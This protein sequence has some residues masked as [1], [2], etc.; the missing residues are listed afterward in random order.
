MGTNELHPKVRRAEQ[1]RKKLLRSHKS[2]KKILHHT[3][4]WWKAWHK[5]WL[6]DSSKRWD[7]DELKE[8]LKKGEM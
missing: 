2:N 1:Y 5:T 6:S 4:K 8:I 7:L 3:R